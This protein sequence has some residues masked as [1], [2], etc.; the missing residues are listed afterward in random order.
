MQP[1]QK[2]IVNVGAISWR[3]VFLFFNAAKMWELSQ[4]AISLGCDCFA[5]APRTEFML[6]A[7][8]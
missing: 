3:Y 1:T 5:I 4:P 2:R 7:Q 8:R 6:I